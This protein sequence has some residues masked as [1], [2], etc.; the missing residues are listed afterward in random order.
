MMQHNRRRLM[1]AA[2]VAAMLAIGPGTLARAQAPAKERVKG[3]VQGTDGG[4]AKCNLALNNVR[5]RLADLGAGNVQIELVTYGP[6][7]GMLRANSEVGPR[8]EE[9]LAAGVKVLA[10][11]NTMKGQK[12]AQKD[13]LDGI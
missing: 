13:M 11:E 3:V 1:Y 12:L 9:A 8:V 6:G 5:N 2:A 4:P 7:I 10:C